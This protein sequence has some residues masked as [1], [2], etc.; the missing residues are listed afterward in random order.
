MRSAGVRL[1]LD[2]NPVAL[3]RLAEGVA[4]RVARR[5]DPA[6]IKL[7]MRAFAGRTGL[8]VS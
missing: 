3:R 2:T 4:L 7:W 8:P 1:P 5:D 6:A